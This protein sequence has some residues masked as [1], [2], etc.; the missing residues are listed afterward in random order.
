VGYGFGR[1]PV[2]FRGP[3]G[4]NIYPGVVSNCSACHVGSI[5]ADFPAATGTTTSTSGNSSQP[6]NYLRTTKATAVCGTCHTGQL[7]SD[8]MLQNGGHYRLTQ[9]QI[10]A[11]Q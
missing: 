7:V 10:N 6:Q 2:D 4:S 11:L 1:N 8:H 9:A 3:T 5:T